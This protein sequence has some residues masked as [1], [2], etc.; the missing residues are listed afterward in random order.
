MSGIKS[1]CLAILGLSLVFSTLPVPVLSAA[2]P[3]GPR[4]A[5][6]RHTALVDG[7]GSCDE[8]VERAIFVGYLVD[9]AYA[10]VADPDD[11]DDDDDQ[12][13]QVGSA[14]VAIDSD[15]ARRHDPPAC[16]GVVFFDVVVRG[17]KTLLAVFSRAGPPGDD[18]AADEELHA[19]LLLQGPRTTAAVARFDVVSG[20]RP[21]GL[22]PPTA[23]GRPSLLRPVARVVSIPGNRLET[24]GPGSPVPRSTPR[25]AALA[26]PVPFS[27]RAAEAA[28]PWASST[29]WAPASAPD[30]R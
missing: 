7:D 13:D 26:A 28:G 29:A 30:P 2:E 18:A 23:S 10:F 11:D 8:P 6:G 17:K 19:S 27:P 5:A 16:R 4:R 1:M 24:R 21:A 3:D 25:D 20:R 12:G 9:P 15:L 14:P 22:S